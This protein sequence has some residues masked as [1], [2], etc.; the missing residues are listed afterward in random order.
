MNIVWDKLTLQLEFITYKVILR[1]QMVTCSY[2]RKKYMI[3]NFGALYVEMEGSRD[4]EKSK[5]GR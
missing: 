2:F 4:I 3:W 5:T 1:R